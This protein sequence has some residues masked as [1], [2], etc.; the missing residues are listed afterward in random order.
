MW[1]SCAHLFLQ[2]LANNDLEIV[3]VSEGVRFCTLVR[4]NSL[5]SCS[6]EI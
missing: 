2:Y 3:E 1:S 5:V 6:G 4:T